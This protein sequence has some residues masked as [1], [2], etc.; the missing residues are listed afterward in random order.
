MRRLYFLACLA[1]CL[2]ALSG[3]AAVIHAH[4]AQTFGVVAGLPDPALAVRP[5]SIR[6]VNVALEQYPNPEAV[7][8][9]LPGLPW[10]RQTFPW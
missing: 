3:L 4:A 7:V 6:G 8:A 10:L 9:Q 5:A 1:L 2:A